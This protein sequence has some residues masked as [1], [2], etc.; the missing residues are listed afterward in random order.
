MRGPS[1]EPR[2]PDAANQPSFSPRPRW[3]RSATKAE[4][5]GE[6]IAVAKPWRKRTATRLV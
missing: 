3:E 2:S 5:T 1:V 6:K 4:A